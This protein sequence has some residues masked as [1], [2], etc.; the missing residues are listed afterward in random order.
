[1]FNL[2]IAERGIADN[3]VVQVQCGKGG[4]NGLWHDALRYQ[5][6]TIVRCPKCSSFNVID[7]H[8]IHYL[9]A[10]DA[11]KAPQSSQPAVESEP[12]Q[13]SRGNVS[14]NEYV[15]PYCGS[16]LQGSALITIKTSMQVGV[17][18]FQTNCSSCGKVITKRDIESSFSDET[19]P[20]AEP[21]PLASQSSNIPKS[22]LSMSELLKSIADKYRSL[23]YQVISQ[24]ANTVI[25]E[26]RASADVVVVV[27]LLFSV[28]L[29]AL[30]YAL[31]ISRKIYRVQLS[32]TP[33]GGVDELGDTIHKFE[34][35]KR[36]AR[37]IGKIIA[38]IDVV[39]YVGICVL[40][41]LLLA[42]GRPD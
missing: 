37:K 20:R 8:N 35:D 17:I 5:D 25:M 39:I 15:C 9:E 13:E 24:S 14:T 36:R 16:E 21:T 18:D 40:I 3:F 29:A 11:L 32:V 38:I 27:A 31:L 7:T 34:G 10:F 23:D 1:M 28:W 4:C 41:P 6:K 42:G 19:E 12:K 2:G 22:D 30:I 26:R 33:T